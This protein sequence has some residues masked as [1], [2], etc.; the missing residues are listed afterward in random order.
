[1]WM[2]LGLTLLS[3]IGLGVALDRLVLD[4][5]MESRGQSHDRGEHR[6]R[7]VQR[8]ERELGLSSEQK[9]QLEQ[10]LEAHGKNARECREGA[11][12]EYAKLRERFREDVR[13][14]LTP[15]QRGRFDEMLAR[16]KHG[17]RDDGNRR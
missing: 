1:M 6:K 7:Y 3:G 13:S 2:V 8:L 16:K 5:A 4:S 14:L 15:E 12:S 17:R 11:R 10:A 9:A